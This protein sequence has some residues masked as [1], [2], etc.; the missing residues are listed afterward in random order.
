MRHRVSKSLAVA[1]FACS[2]LAA[3]PAL[4]APAGRIGTNLEAFTTVKLTEPAPAEGLQVTITSDDER[5]LLFAIAADQRGS[6]TLTLQVPP[7]QSQTP[8]FYIQALAGHGPATY[9]VSAPGCSTAKGTIEILRSAITIGGPSNSSSFRT[10]TGRARNITAQTALLDELGNVVG[11]LPIAGGFTI[12]VDIRSSNPNVGSV[13]PSSLLFTGGDSTQAA[14]FKPVAAGDVVL[15]ASVPESFA[16]AAKSNLNVR[17]EL[18]G[19][20]LL[21]DINLGKDLQVRGDVMLGQDAPANGLD[22]TL[23]SADPA[24]LL[25]STRENELGSKCTTLHISAGKGTAPYYIQ[26]LADSGI[27]QYTATAPGYRTRVANIA[28]NPSGVMIVFSPYGPP[29]EQ[30]VLHP[31]PAPKER[32]FFAS[33][34]EHKQLWLS[35]WSV[36]L[37][38]KT[39]RGADITAQKL[40]PGISVPVELKN[41]N[42]SVGDVASSVVL[43]NKAFAAITEFKPVR[44]G[45]TTIS[46]NTPPGFITPSNATSVTAVIRP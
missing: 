9:T 1:L 22:I 14:Q 2:A 29:D 45:E 11:S 32:P 21:M 36:Y 41:G 15:S 20:G 17:V 44:P 13:S 24:R 31:M 28:L 34:S 7:R 18:P 19:I 38:P 33:L 26:A 23:T 42:P 40:R 25:L 5:Q 6:K 39:D 10:T 16:I 30:E 4:L 12:K 46:V 8:D 43:S 3:A 27:A 37:D 35:V